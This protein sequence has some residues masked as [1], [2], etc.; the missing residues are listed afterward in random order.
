MRPADREFPPSESDW[1]VPAEIG[2][3]TVSRPILKWVALVV[4]AVAAVAAIIAGAVALWAIRQMNPPGKPGAATTFVV[5][6]RDDVVSLS[7][8]LADEGFITHAGVFQ[9][10]VGRKGGLDPVPGYYTLRPR[11]TMGNLVRALRT[12]PSA[13]YT[14][15][16]FPEGLTI[17]Q[18]A[19][20]LHDRVPRLSAI[21]P[22]TRLTSPVAAFCTTTHVSR[23]VAGV[24]SRVRAK[25]W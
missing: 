13:T 24:P 16:T 15:V 7:H 10:Y 21:G 22:A 2:T 23:L 6:Q 20:R 4:V 17:E 8:R 11:D 5:D 12:P 19:S 18:M 25:A 1:L 14:S 3:T 9:W